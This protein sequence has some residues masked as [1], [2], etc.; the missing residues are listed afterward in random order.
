MRGKPAPKRDIEIDYKFSSPLIAK[1]I[2]QL[3]RQGKKTIAQKIL[4]SS[5]EIISQKTKQDPLDVL[6]K[7]MKNVAPQLEVKSRRIGGAHYQIPMEVRGD[8]RNTLAMRWIIA[9]AKSRKG[10]PMKEKLALELIDASNRMG[11]AYK[12]ME[13]VRRMAEANRAFAHFA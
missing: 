13:D 10:K 2:K 4:Y 11:E 5:F 12:K 1:F 6:D 3:M 7:A 9:A 8:R